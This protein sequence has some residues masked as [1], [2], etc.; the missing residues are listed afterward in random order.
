MHFDLTADATMLAKTRRHSSRNSDLPQL[1]WI[2]LRAGSPATRV[3]AHERFTSPYKNS[4]GRSLGFRA[5]L[6]TRQLRHRERKSRS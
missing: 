1:E 3:L 6:Q 5:Y 2:A 4:S